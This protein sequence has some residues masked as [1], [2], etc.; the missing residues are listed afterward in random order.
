MS[1]ITTI[2]VL[3]LDLD[4]AAAAMRRLDGELH[5]GRTEFTY[6]AG[7]KGVCDHAISFRDT[8]YEMGLKRRQ[9]GKG[10]DLLWDPDMAYFQPEKFGAGAGKL[11]QAYATEVAIKAARRQGYS[12]TETRAQDGSTVLKVRA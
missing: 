8:A 1:H 7:Q 10:F 6:Y 4:A 2:A 3:I 12:V 11:K 5:R 9:D